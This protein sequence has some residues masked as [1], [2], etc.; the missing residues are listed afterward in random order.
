MRDFIT[1]LGAVSRGEVT[2]EEAG[3]L[4][5]LLWR[6]VRLRTPACRALYRG[7]KANKAKAERL[8]ELAV[9]LK[10]LKCGPDTGSRPFNICRVESR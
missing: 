4:M 9:E 5:A 1:C 7:T 6:G 8:A 2:V 3:E 10:L